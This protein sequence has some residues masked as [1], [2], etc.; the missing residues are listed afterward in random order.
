MIDLTNEQNTLVRH[1]YCAPSQHLHAH[2]FKIPRFTVY[3]IAVTRLVVCCTNA[4][5]KAYLTGV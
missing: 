1:S 5:P 2:V 3:S 4:L